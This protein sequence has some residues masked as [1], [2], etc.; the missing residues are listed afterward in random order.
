V[1]YILETIQQ[2]LLISTSTAKAVS[3]RIGPLQAAQFIADSW[4]RLSTEII[5]NGFAHE[6]SHIETC[7][8]RTR[9]TVTVHHVGNYEQFPHSN[10]SLQYYKEKEG[11][12]EANAAKQQETTEDEE[13]RRSVNE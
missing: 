2:N 3:A 9:P 1:N 5:Q 4:R 10:K 13:T 6:V 12:V 11:R 8:C 7:R